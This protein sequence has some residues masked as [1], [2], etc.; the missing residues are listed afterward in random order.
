VTLDCVS[1]RP[2]R[3]MAGIVKRN[4]KYLSI[5]MATV[6]GK[7]VGQEDDECELEACLGL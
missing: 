1:I 5:D 4:L 7:P 6:I 3:D 2:M